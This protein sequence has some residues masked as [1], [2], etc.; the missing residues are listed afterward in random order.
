MDRHTRYR[1]GR[2]T[3]DPRL[4]QVLV[5]G[6]PVETQPKAFDVLLYLLRH[7]DRVVDKSELLSALWPGVVVSDSALNQALRKARAMVGDDGGAQRVIR[8]MQRRGFRFVADLEEL[9]GDGED[10]P[11]P[12][13]PAPTGA[14][15]AVL[16]FAD[17]SPAGDQ[18]Y[19]C[20]GMTEEVITALTR[21]PKLRVAARTSVFAFK[22][23]ADDVREI[24]RQLGVASVVEGS[25]RKSGDRLRVTAQLIDAKTGFHLW[26]ERW[27]RGVEDMLVIQDEI[28]ERIAEAL[29]TGTPARPDAAMTPAENFSAR[30]W[31]YVHRFG[32]R[33]QR[34]A[35]ELFHQALAIDPDCARA[36][37]G[38]A[39]SEVLLYRYSDATDARRENALAA[40]RRAVEL[41][42]NSADAWTA[43]GAAMTICCEFADAATAFERAIA[44][45]P[46]H[47][48]AH[49]YYARAC[50]ETG[51]FVKAVA[52]YEL[53][54]SG[55][56]DDYQAWFFAAQS[57]RS[58]GRSDREQAMERH[59]LEAAERALEQDPT[60][61]RALSIGACAWLNLGRPEKMREWL[62]R[63][64]A[65]E[66][67][68]PYVL[69][70]LACGY[71]RLGERD[72]AL[73]LLEQ[74][75]VGRMANRSWIDHDSDL[76]PLRDHPRFKALYARAR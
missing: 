75:D 16:P 44:L 36:W 21:T 25:V 73:D 47:F 23:R 43:R 8:T 1:F 33:A 19:F 59:L 38:L 64:S 37:A 2:C 22:H 5:D 13:P 61:A 24:G 54:A 27:D 56:P 9:E 12:V 11:A 58:L 28:A 17:M 68:E 10:A 66:P 31:S 7:R 45:A 74:V 62:E 49:Y 63:S 72:R 53:A 41:A 40:A 52:H 35:Q 70:N 67:D 4:R 34:F 60:D 39:L 50:S 15:V 26:S 51:D 69:Y 18:Q 32:T 3:V 48:E 6:D 46:R 65:L 55:R 20:D 30:G 29:R 71:S 14:S 76:D 57:Y 42:P